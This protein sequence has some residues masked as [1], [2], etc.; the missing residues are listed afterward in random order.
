MCPSSSWWILKRAVKCY[1][2]LFDECSKSLQ[3]LGP[4]IPEQ[5]TRI[6]TFIEDMQRSVSIE[7]PVSLLDLTTTV[8]HGGVAGHADTERGTFLTPKEFVEK[9]VLDALIKAAI[10]LEKLILNNCNSLEAA[11]L[12]YV[13]FFAL[14]I[15]KSTNNL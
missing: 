4:L 2:P 8:G 7:R 15:P 5:N 11:V 14:Q 10:D 3:G 12:S 1:N 13:E 6:G 9:F